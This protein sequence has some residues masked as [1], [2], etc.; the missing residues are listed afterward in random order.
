MTSLAGM[1][2]QRSSR[3]TPFVLPS[4][5]T[6]W[7]SAQCAVGSAQWAIVHVDRAGPA[8]S[9]GVETERVAVLEMIVE[10]CGEERMRA[11]DR[12]KVA[13]EVQVDVLHRQDLGVTA[14]RRAAFHPE[15]RAQTRLAHAEN[16]VRANAPKRLG[17]AD[18]DIRRPVWD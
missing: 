16:R 9:L 18:A 2:T 11:R 13:G 15:H 6:A 14:A 4:P 1:I 10:Q 8:D 12:V 3:T 17:E 5:I 7:R